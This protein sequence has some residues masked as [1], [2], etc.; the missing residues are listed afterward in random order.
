[1]EYQSIMIATFDSKPSKIYGRTL[2][3][4]GNNSTLV[5]M[6]GVIGCSYTG[7]GNGSGGDILGSVGEYRD[8]P[9][10]WMR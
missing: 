8:D 3:I 10:I 1:M 5:N 6:C 2:A 7:L 4:L 9:F